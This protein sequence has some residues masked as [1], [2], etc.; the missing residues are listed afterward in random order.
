MGK[1][2][3]IGRSC[4]RYVACDG[5]ALRTMRCEKDRLPILK[6]F[7]NS[8]AASAGMSSTSPL[9]SKRAGALAQHCVGRKGNRARQSRA[10]RIEARRARAARK[11]LYSPPW[12]LLAS[13][14][15]GRRR[16]KGRSVDRPV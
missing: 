11:L 3:A 14:S 9:K 1:E 12:Y 2:R 6:P 10:S 13:D 15:L 5:R 7:L 4:D 16:G 8:G